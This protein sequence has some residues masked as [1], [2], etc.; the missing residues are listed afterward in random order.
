MEKILDKILLIKPQ[1]DNTYVRRLSMSYGYY[2]ALAIV[3]EQNR[4]THMGIDNSFQ[5]KNFMDLTDKER[6]YLGVDK[7][8]SIKENDMMSIYRVNKTLKLNHSVKLRKP[9]LNMRYSIPE[10]THDVKNMIRAT[11]KDK[12]DMLNI[13]VNNNTNEDILI[14]LNLNTDYEYDEDLMK[15]DEL[16]DKAQ[17]R[18]I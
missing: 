3:N 7:C 16:E 12:S 8:R 18:L 4:V 6:N 15:Y 17:T 13:R 10:E 2:S 11:L 1:D 14:K 5:I 9:C